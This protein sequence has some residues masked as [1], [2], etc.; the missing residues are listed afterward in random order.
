MINEINGDLF[1]CPENS[2]LAHC[3][4]VHL[5]MNLGIAKIFKTKYKYVSVLKDQNVGIG[6][7]AIL[8]DNNRFIYYLVTKK[9]Y[10]NKPTY[11]SLEKSL[12][13]MVSHCIEN[14]VKKLSIPRIGCGLDK[15][16]WDKIKE[17]IEKVFKD[18]GIDIDVYYL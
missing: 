16:K 2:S 6:G 3:V 4:S 1:T 13:T 12:N 7:V 14:N 5:H 15:L 11:Y 9:S 10:W 17:I 18:T 8:Q